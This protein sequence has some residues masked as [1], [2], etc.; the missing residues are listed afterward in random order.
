VNFHKYH[1]KP[2]TVDGI[3]FASKAEAA[4]YGVLKMLQRGGAI[5]ALTLQVKF[6]IVVN[7]IKI[8]TYI[9]D[10]V[11]KENGRDVVED[12]KGILT[13]AYRL[14]RKLMLACHGITVLETK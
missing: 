3:R 6:P 5:S 7:E 2:T 14:K 12:V 9:A 4:R 10:F 8:C 1:A 11:Y 13:P